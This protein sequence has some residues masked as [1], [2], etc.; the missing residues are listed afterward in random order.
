MALPGVKVGP[1]DPDAT[2]SFGQVSAHSNARTLIRLHARMHPPELTRHLARKLDPSRTKGLLLSEV[3][4]YLAGLKH[5]NGDPY[6]PK[7]AMVEGAAVRG[8]PDTEQ[9]L[10][11]VYR[12]A[13]GRTGKWFAPYTADALPDSYESGTELSKVKEMRD[14]GVVAFDSEGTATEILR[15]EAAELR[16]QN[17]ALRKMAEGQAA[18]AD[19]ELPEAP[20]GDTRPSNVIVDDNEQL[21]RQNEELLARVADLEAAV[22][23][24]PGEKDASL[25]DTASA[26]PPV[27]GYENLN[28]NDAI[29]FLKADDT[30]PEARE[31]ILAYERSHANRRSVVAAGEAVVGTGG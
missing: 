9:V 18:N 29:K 17:D 16:R 25:P 3:R 30:S 27:E 14:R 7:G 13:K 20:A 8:E 19:G 26:S 6:V 31:A 22:D 12:N 21:R 23:A 28:A 4:S 1:L 11:Y 15:R 5:D 24:P 2:E 10:T